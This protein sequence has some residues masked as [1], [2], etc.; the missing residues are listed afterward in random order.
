MGY[1][2]GVL[3]AGKSLREAGEESEGTGAAKV[4]A[5]LGEDEVL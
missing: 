1:T 4:C 5:G 3:V 2:G